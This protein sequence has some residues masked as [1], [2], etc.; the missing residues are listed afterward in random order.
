MMDQEAYKFLMVSLRKGFVTEDQASEAC[1]IFDS[2]EKAKPVSFVMMDLGYITAEQMDEVVQEIVGALFE[3][4]VP[5]EG[6]EVDEAELDAIIEEGGQ[7]LRRGD[8]PL[9]RD[10][11]RR[12]RRE[13]PGR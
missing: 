12:D 1:R 11:A 3:D 5:S 4:E 2:A 6:P 10:R 7:R 9:R 13:D 8:R